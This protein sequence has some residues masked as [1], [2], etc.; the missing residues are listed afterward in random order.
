MA[1]LVKLRTGQ[2]NAAHEEV[3]HNEKEWQFLQSEH[4]DD[5]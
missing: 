4:D 2:M 5:S 1:S 3:S